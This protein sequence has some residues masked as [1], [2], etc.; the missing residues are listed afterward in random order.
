MGT[1]CAVRGIAETTPQ[2]K[3]RRLDVPVDTSGAAHDRDQR[4]M[5][6]EKSTSCAT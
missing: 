5:T 4:L 6:P 2:T 3:T 1:A